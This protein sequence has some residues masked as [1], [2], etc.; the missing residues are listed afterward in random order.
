VSISSADELSLAEQQRAQELKLQRAAAEAEASAEAEAALL[1]RQRA[2]D[3]L[4][5]AVA[6]EVGNPSPN[7][8]AQLTPN[9]FFI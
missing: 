7:P 9:L 1:R 2:E 3:K 8:I 4:I 6:R 5:N